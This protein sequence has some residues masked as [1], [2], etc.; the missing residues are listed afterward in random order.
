MSPI[1]FHFSFLPSGEIIFGGRNDIVIAN[2][3]ELKR[4][5]E[6]PVP[7]ITEMQVLNQPISF[8]V[9]GSPV[10]LKYKQN[11]FSIGF[12]AQAYT[13]AK[14]VKFRYRLNRFDEWTEGTGRRFAK[15]YKCS[16]RRLCF[17][18]TGCLIMK[19]YGMKK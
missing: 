11:F 7:Y 5:T 9:N 6:I 8:D 10:S 12:S 4:N 16:R 17:S 13:M 1:F 2:P 18:T 14:D 3:A 15:L 19:E